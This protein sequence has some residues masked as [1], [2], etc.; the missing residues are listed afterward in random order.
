[1]YYEL[2]KQASPNGGA[3]FFDKKEA[4]L[5]G[6]I[7]SPPKNLGRQQQGEPHPTPEI[8]GVAII[9]CIKKQGHAW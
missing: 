1:M 9:H 8:F 4:G 6:P 5:E 2:K 3:C 7:V